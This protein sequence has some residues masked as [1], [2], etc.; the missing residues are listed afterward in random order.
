[1][2]LAVSVET[3]LAQKFLIHRLRSGSSRHYA[4]QILKG[5]HRSKLHGSGLELDETRQYQSGDDVRQMDWRISARLGKPYVR[6]VTEEKRKNVRLCVDLRSSMYW[7]TQGQPKSVLAMET[8]A[9]LGWWHLSEGDRVG[10]TV[11]T[12]DAVLQFQ[13]SARTP[14]WVRVLT[15]MVE[16]Q[17]TEMGAQV[18]VDIAKVT[19]ELGELRQ[20]DRGYWLSS[21]ADCPHDWMPRGDWVLLPI[22]DAFEQGWDGLSSLV[23]SDG[24]AQLQFSG[25]QRMKM[26]QR[27]GEL[28]AMQ[29]ADWLRWGQRLKAN[30]WP[31]ATQTSALEQLQGWLRG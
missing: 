31:M 26:S 27:Q 8:A 17:P 28:N 23:L 18:S 11:L 30:V 4:R 7:A 29:Q 13:P 20:G 19:A 15:A 12:D 21:I 25:E 24:V 3:L 1:M 16:A 5:A 10:A 6:L 9:L 22:A 14:D 2:S